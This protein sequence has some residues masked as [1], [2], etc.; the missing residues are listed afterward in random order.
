MDL[1]VVSSNRRRQKW[2]EENEVELQQV[3]HPKP[4]AI[5]LRE[6]RG[7]RITNN[8]LIFHTSSEFRASGQKA[9]SLE[10]ISPGINEIY[11]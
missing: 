3:R 5:V 6:D 2:N 8:I 10:C 4:G 7:Q 11:A 9:G 1:T